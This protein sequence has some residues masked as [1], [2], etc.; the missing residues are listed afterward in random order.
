M[1]PSLYPAHTLFTLELLCLLSILLIVTIWRA[2]QDSEGCNFK[3]KFG[4]CRIAEKTRVL[5]LD[6]SVAGIVSQSVC[7]RYWFDQGWFSILGEFESAGC[8]NKHLIYLYIL[9]R[10]F[11]GKIIFF[12]GF[13]N[14]FG[15]CLNWQR[16]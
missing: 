9:F 8:I 1:T 6:L 5:C 7:S 11:L 4:G 12:W 13:K 2:C 3:I 15:K 16:Q 14:N 10:L